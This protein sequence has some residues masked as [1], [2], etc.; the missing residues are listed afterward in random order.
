[1]LCT[2]MLLCYESKEERQLI[3]GYCPRSVT[4]PGN[5]V[6]ETTSDFCHEKWVLPDGEVV[7]MK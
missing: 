7:T 4:S 5:Q 1:M 6:Q 2:M 3:K